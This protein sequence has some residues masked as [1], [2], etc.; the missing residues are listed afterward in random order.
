MHVSGG[1]RIQLGTFETEE[2]AAKA[3]DKCV[4]QRSRRS[5][6][7]GRGSLRRAT[8]LAKGDASGPNLGPLTAAELES[9]SGVTLAQFAA[10][11]K[12]ARKK[13]ASGTSAFHGVGWHKHRGKWNAYVWNGGKQKGLGYFNDE[14]EAARAYDKCVSPALWRFCFALLLWAFGFAFAPRTALLCFRR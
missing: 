2:L 12:A 9:L 13:H 3:F 10:S 11:A 14:V 5:T 8:F 7:T 1:T 4:A 6:L